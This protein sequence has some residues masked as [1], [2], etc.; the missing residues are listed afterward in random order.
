MHPHPQYDL[1][2][3]GRCHCARPQGKLALVTLNVFRNPNLICLKSKTCVCSLAFL[4]KDTKSDC[5][6]CKVTLCSVNYIYVNI[7]AAQMCLN[8]AQF[9]NIICPLSAECSDSNVTFTLH[10]EQVGEADLM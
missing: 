8:E 10:T 6:Y 4:S 3:G 1:V 7:L 9:V 2:V 5:S